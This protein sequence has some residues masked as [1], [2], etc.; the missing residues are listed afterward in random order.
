[1]AVVLVRAVG[2]AL[3]LVNEHRHCCRARVVGGEVRWRW[4]V[5]RWHRRL[6]VV[7]AQT[8]ALLIRRLRMS[9]GGR[10]DDDFCQR[11]CEKFSLVNEVNKRLFTVFKVT[12]VD[13]LL[14]VTVL[15]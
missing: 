7:V 1:M 5:H 4:R 14:V 8:L 9:C 15:H 6:D 2:T 13:F 3:A 11:L 12:F 10:L